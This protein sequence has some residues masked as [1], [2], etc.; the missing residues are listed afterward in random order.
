M[1]GV[2]LCGLHTPH[3]V[4]T[5]GVG[6]ISDGAGRVMLTG[7]LKAEYTLSM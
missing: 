2:L 1:S 6:P 7:S 3:G 4:I 5:V